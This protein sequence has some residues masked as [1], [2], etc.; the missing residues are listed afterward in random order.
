[1]AYTGKESKKRVD[2]C[3]CITDSLCLT[4]ETNTTLQLNYTPIKSFKKQRYAHPYVNISPIHDGQ[5]METT[6]T[7]IDHWMNKDVH[8]YNGILLSHEKWNNASTCSYMN[9]PRD[10]H[11]KWIKSER[12][13]QIQYDI[14]Y[15][16]D[17]KKW[18]K[19]TYKTETHSKT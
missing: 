9:G 1:M 8:V 19:W 2:I 4:A 15:T 16:W 12:E 17:L 3:I 18:H 6:Y 13:R 5:D 11:T 14:T 10:D 7:S